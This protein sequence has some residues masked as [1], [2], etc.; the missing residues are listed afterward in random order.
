MGKRFQAGIITANP[1][2]PTADMQDDAAPGV[3]T[4]VDQLRFINASTW[5]TAG[6]SAAIGLRYGGTTSSAGGTGDAINTVQKIVVDTLGNATD[7]G[8][9]SA[10]RMRVGAAGSNT[11]GIVH[12]G[13]ILGATGGLVTLE[14]F[15]Y[16][17]AGNATD[18]GD[19]TAR[20]YDSGS[21]SSNTRMLLLGG[22]SA[23]SPYYFNTIE[24]CVIAST[25]NTTDFGDLTTSRGYGN[26]GQI[27]SKTRALYCGG[28][29]DAQNET[30]D[31]VTIASAANA[32]DFGD[33]TDG[34]VYGSAGM[35]NT[36]RGV[37]GG[38]REGGV[39]GKN[40]L[41]YFTISSTGNAT[42]FGDLSSAL[43][44]TAGVSNA[45]R[46]VAMGGK[47]SSSLVSQMDYI[48]LASAGNS[49]DFGDM[50][51]DVQIAGSSCSG[52]P[53]AQA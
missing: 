17:S 15:T 44:D 12:G 10:V 20:M 28:N 52:T 36:T 2:H 6:K 8:Y 25:G 29:P 22:E 50:H 14:Y 41:Q 47:V 23:D 7:F 26:H 43:E 40:I 11:R 19:R 3:W 42:D 32:T 30:V 31:Y 37:I 16:A 24:Q 45:T 33:L 18:F 9:L 13:T 4:L 39:S 46:G 27:N 5:P 48:T 38:G 53:G 1:T 49:S 21:A 35:S 34:G 51:T